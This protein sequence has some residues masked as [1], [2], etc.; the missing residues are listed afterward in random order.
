MTQ[1]SKILTGRL[2]R[3]VLPV[4]AVILIW[5]TVQAQ[6]G[7]RPV[8]TTSDL[9]AL[10]LQERSLRIGI[11]DRWFLV[12]PP[13]DPTRPAP[14]LL[15]LHGGTQSMRRIFAPDAGATRGW[16]EL[17]RR[18]NALLLVPNA[19]NPDDGDPRSDN[20]S[21]NDLR[22][23]VSRI[24]SADDVGFIS[25]LLDWAAGAY[26][27]DRSRVYVT[28]ASNGGMMTFRL[29]MD[30]PERFAAG[31]AV[32]SALPVDDDRLKRPSNPAPLMIANGTLDPLVIWN[33][34]KIAGNRGQTRSV[35]ET[36]RW[37]VD[38]NNAVAQPSTT[39][40]LSDRDPNDSCTIERR[41]YAAGPGGAPV[42]AYTMNGGG[43]SI[44][45]AKF[46]IPDTWLVRRF[47]GPVCRDV[48]GTELIWEFLSSQRR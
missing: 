17:A 28:G 18:E 32:V 39:T 21:W 15:V 26:R 45:S 12:Q 27:T 48:E 20:Q 7:R 40:R 13:P 3:T 9:A 36:V 24:S 33:G 44:P 1:A 23:G 31:A 4:C 38:A 22:H 37:W 14:V 42:I 47:I 6:A 11:T 2:Q 35:A 29:L 19:V 16:P 41:A 30:V 46:Q 25:A 43:H 5:G 8:P 10:G 34:G